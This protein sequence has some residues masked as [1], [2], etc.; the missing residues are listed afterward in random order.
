M[1]NLLPLSAACVRPDK[2]YA[3]YGIRRAFFQTFAG[4]SCLGPHQG[5][6]ESG[7]DLNLRPHESCLLFGCR[8]AI[9]IGEVFEI[10]ANHNI[11]SI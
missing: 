5:I 1:C 4:V 7:G 2:S 8:I 11:Q 6:I 3:L 10:S 9:S